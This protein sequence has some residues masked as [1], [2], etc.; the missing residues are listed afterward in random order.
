MSNMRRIDKNIVLSKFN[1]S[2]IKGVIDLF[3]SPDALIL[4]DEITSLI[5]DEIRI[6]SDDR[7]TRILEYIN[8][9]ENL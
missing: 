6:N 1:K 8:K 2:G 5:H 7:E 4:I 3:D 9:I